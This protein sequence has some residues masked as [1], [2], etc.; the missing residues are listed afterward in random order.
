[1]IGR[2]SELERLGRFLA[3]PGPALAWITGFSGS[4]STALVRAATRETG[5]LWLRGS[6]LPPELAGR[7]AE[8]GLREQVGDVADPEIP[9]PGEEAAGPWRGTFRRLHAA[10]RRP[11]PPTL[12]LDRAHLLLQDRRF[13]RGLEALWSDLRAHGRR[14]HL[15]IAST[16][17]AVPEGWVRGG[18]GQGDGPRPGGAEIVLGPLRLRE[19]AAAVPDWSA[20][21]CITLYG[22]VG[23]LPGFW[24]RVDSRVRPETNLSRLLLGPEA[25]CRGLADGLLPPTIGES[26]RSLALIHALAR[27]AGSWGELRT[28]AAVFRSSSELGPYMKGLVDAD[29]VE[30]DRSLDASPRSRSRRYRLVHPLLAFWFGTVRPRLAELDAGA[31]PNPVLSERLA[32]EIPGLLQRVLPRLGQEFLTHHG[33]ERLPAR[34][35]EAGAVWGDGYDLEVAGTLHSGAAVYGHVHW[36][37][38]APSP[39]SMDR[40]GD[41]IRSA[42]YGFGREARLR[43]L[44][45]REEPHHDLARRTAQIPGAYLLGPSDLVGRP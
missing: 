15:L 19:V 33:D 38:P 17:A 4:G 29:L 34:A 24:S 12:V 1:M 25:S 10:A 16:G 44:L 36:A 11:Q 2:E 42:R 30:V 40:L 23:G 18:D 3:G 28:G 5:A 14:Q 22:L 31:P 9:A 8:A 13:V 37:G 7:E 20:L 26:R 6:S 43:L 41:E 32:P 21:E 35:R 45:L 27:G 39:E